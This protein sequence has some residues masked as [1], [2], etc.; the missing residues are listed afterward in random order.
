MASEGGL[1]DKVESLISRDDLVFNP[2]ARIEIP[3][4]IRELKNIFIN[5]VIDEFYEHLQHDEEER[6]WAMMQFGIRLNKRIFMCLEERKGDR[7]WYL[8]VKIERVMRE[9]EKKVLRYV[10][11][12]KF[13]TIPVVFVEERK[14]S[15][16]IIRRFL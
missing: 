3:E 13:N 15:S 16:L 12:N 14:G 6:F 1:F 4:N 9:E 7:S 10:A 2:E 11:E 5:F 8:V